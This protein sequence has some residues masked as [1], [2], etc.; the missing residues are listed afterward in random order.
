M[1]RTRASGPSRSV[2]ATATRSN[3]A[4]RGDLI[5]VGE[6]DGT[7]AAREIREFEAGADSEVVHGARTTSEFIWTRANT[8]RF[9]ERDNYSIAMM[10]ES[11]YD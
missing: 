8:G 11:M 7:L 2:R 10:M 3:G 5:I 4:S 6:P 1:A 9:I